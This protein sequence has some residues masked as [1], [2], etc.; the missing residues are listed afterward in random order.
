MSHTHNGFTLIELIVVLALAGIVLGIG[1]PSLNHLSEQVH[2]ARISRQLM[3]QVNFARAT[4]LNLNRTV[5]LCPSADGIICS[6]TGSRHWLVFSDQNNNRRIDGDET[7]Y[8]HTRVPGK[9]AIRFAVSRG[10]NY[11]RFE[12]DGRAIEF[13]NITYC[14]AA[15]NGKYIQSVIVSFNGRPR[16]AR[17]RN[18]DGIPEDANGRN[19]SC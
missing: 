8:T 1:I 16:L 4:A 19:I 2:A 9:G 3:V 15:S 13:G 5:T 18:G 10:A 12:P 6:K 14:P 11:M 17:D 7:V